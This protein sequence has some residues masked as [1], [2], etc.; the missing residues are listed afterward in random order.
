METKKRGYGQF[1]K[2]IPEEKGQVLPL[3]VLFLPLTVLLLGLV[4]DL[5]LLF[6]TRLTM[7]AAADLGALAG[8]QEVNLERLAKGQLWLEEE[9]ASAEA[10]KVTLDNLNQNPVLGPVGEIKVKTINAD[11]KN[12]L[13]HPVTGRLLTDPTVTVQVKV[14]FRPPFLSQV[15]PEIPIQVHADASLLERK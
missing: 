12:P 9:T 7:L 15:F 5:G 1:R 11:T 13:P 2:E 8:V 4:V 3:V 14:F 10:T 6:S